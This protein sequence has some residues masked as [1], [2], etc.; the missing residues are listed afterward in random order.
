[1]SRRPSERKIEKKEDKGKEKVQ[2]CLTCD[3]YINRDLFSRPVPIS[4]AERVRVPGLAVA[5]RH[6][7]AVLPAFSPTAGFLH[8]H[9]I[10]GQ[11]WWERPFQLPATPGQHVKGIET[12]MHLANCYAHSLSA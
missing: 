11:T 5:D 4:A 3:I 9:L 7:T 6:A 1:M 2:L 12:K 8:L 10:S